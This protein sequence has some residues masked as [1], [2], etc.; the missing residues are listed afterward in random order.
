MTK[1]FA[2]ALILTSFSVLAHVEPGNYTGKD[3]NGVSCTFTIG[4]VWFENDMHH[5]LNERLPVSHIAFNGKNADGVIWNLGHP[6]VVN[7]EAG[8]NRFNHDI[9]QQI[10]PN[11]TGAASVTVIKRDEASE[12]TSPVA[13]IYIEDN[14]RSKADSKKMTCAL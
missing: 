10:V 14:Y 5:P 13:I 4:E 8:L 3:Q 1:F 2:L 11:K 6:P 9:F 7:T 12:D